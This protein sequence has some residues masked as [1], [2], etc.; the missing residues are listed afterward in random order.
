MK[1]TAPHQGLSIDFAFTGQAS[2]DK[3][4]AA[5]CKGINGEMCFVVIKDHHTGTLDGTV[6]ISKGAPVN[7]LR[8]WLARHSPQVADKQVH[9]DQGGELHNNPQIRALFHE[10]GYDMCP[11]GADLSHQNGPV[12]RAHQTIGDALRALL[13]GAD[14]DPRFWPHAFFTS[15]AS[16]MHFLAKTM[17]VST[18]V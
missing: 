5:A 14:L 15:C 9:M 8:Q 2:K 16:R 7:W 1:A 10:F 13:S 4:R 12:E 6:C 18:K 3:S 17:F 11:N